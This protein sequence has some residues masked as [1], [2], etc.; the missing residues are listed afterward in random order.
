MLSSFCSTSFKSFSML[1]AFIRPSCCPCG[2]LPGSLGVLALAAIVPA[3]E[4]AKEM[5]R[6]PVFLSRGNET[7]A[8]TTVPSIKTQG[9]NCVQCSW[10]QVP[11]PS[12]SVL[13]CASQQQDPAVISPAADCICMSP[14]LYHVVAMEGLDWGE[15]GD[16]IR[17]ESGQGRH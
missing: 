4:T 16:A 17:T 11:P 6:H 7:L 13:S 9:R 14:H 12:H 2:E 8:N 1:E 5:K 3:E 15:R 10:V